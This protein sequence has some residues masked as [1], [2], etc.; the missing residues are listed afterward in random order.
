V[1]RGLTGNEVPAVPESATKHCTQCDQVKPVSE[2]NIRR[3]SRD[4]FCPECKDCKA[5]RGRRHYEENRERLLAQMQQYHEAHREQQLKQ[6]RRYY[7]DQRARVLAHYGTSCACC[8]ATEKLAIDHINGDGGAHRKE[9]FGDPRIGGTLFTIWL[10]KQG[11]PPGY[12]T[13]CVPCNASKRNG[14]SCRLDHGG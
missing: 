8:G 5:K 1:I 13:L 11:F 6:M 3:A 2:F 9:L 7:A 12:Q 10:V 14:D 4:G